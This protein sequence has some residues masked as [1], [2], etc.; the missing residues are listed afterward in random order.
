MSFKELFDKSVD[1]I[2]E[3]RKYIVTI[4]FAILG[5]IILGVLFFFSSDELT[6]SKEVSTLLSNIEQRKYN[7]AI[8]EYNV[9][10]SSF[11]NDKM[12][13]LDKS[14]SKKINKLLLTNGDKYINGQITKEHFVGMINMI[15]SLENIDID[16]RN[17]IDQSKRVA[18]IYIDEKIDYEVAISYINAV[19]SLNSIA[20]ELNEYKQEIKSLNESRE[21]FKESMKHMEIK[22]YHEAILGFD[23]VLEYDKKYYNAAQKSKNKCIDEMRG[24]YIEEAKE[25]NSNGDYEKALQYIEYLKPYYANDEEILRLE[26]E[27]KKNLSLYTLSA[28]DIINLIVRKSGKE[29]E[30]ISINSFQQMV[31]GEKYYY[32]EVYEY[33][34]LIDE[35]LVDPKNKNIYSYK[36]SN[37]DYNSGFSDG[38]F[39]ILEEGSIQFSISQGEA[40][41]LLENKLADKG[42]TYKS[43]S[44]VEL[45]KADSYIKGSETISDMFGKNKNSYYY[46]IVNKGLFRKKEVYAVNMYD[47]KIYSLDQSGVKEYK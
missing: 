38:Y 40:M 37:K 44:V 16:E 19:E 2:D 30:G 36:D 22:K 24:Y 9:Y 17:I 35:V 45:I 15:N 42:N 34:T 8:K 47:K 1:F 31:E 26:K 27:Y 6:V 7:A 11:S 33:D 21:L 28:D 43:I 5:A 13:R 4:S 12:K 29:K 10:E 3:K 14:L 23:K 25:F 32:V 39:K 41:F 20:N 18:D 46:A